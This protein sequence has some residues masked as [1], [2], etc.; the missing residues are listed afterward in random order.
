MRPATPLVEIIP[1]GV[2]DETLSQILAANLE[3]VLGLSSLIAPE[4]DEPE[5]AYAPARDQ[6]DAGPIL[7]ELA[8]RSEGPPLK[9]GLTMVDLCMPILTFVYGESQLGGKAAVMSL[10]R[11]LDI[12]ADVLYQRAAKIGLHEIGH[13]LGLGHCREVGCLMQFSQKIG[14][15]DSLPV[16]FCDACSYEVARCRAILIKKQEALGLG[17]AG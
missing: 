17:P 13:V 14:Q 6:Y 4:Q 8:A 3:A 15:L 7:K 9:L 16:A 11:L 5:Y 12:K 1:L 2:L 10:S